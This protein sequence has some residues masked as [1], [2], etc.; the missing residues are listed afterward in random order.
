MTVIE[1]LGRAVLGVPFVWL[2]YEAAAEPGARVNMA[3]ELGLPQAELVVRLNG[4]AMVVG[5]AALL[6]GVLPRAAAAGLV[7]SLVPTT[8]AGHPFWRQEDPTA[9]K[10]NRI[11]VLKNAG[12]MGG[13]LVIAARPG[14]RSRNA[15]SSK[16]KRGSR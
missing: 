6:G 7:A 9:R 3:K 5:G 11:Q 4:V 10:A 15:G 16:Q 2:G 13:L 8:V 12:L 1:R 14:P